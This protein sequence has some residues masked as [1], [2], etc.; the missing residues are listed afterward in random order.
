MRNLN[1]IVWKLRL[2][3]GS[4]AAIPARRS[5]LRARPRPFRG[6]PALGL[7][8]HSAPAGMD[9]EWVD[10]LTAGHAVRPRLSIKGAS[11]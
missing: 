2:K 9:G 3:A 4:E 1:Q 5:P 11:E 7:C 8:T 10:R 6:A